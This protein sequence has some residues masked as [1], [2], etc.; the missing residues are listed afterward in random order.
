VTAIINKPQSG[1][2]SNVVFAGAD[3]QMLYVTDG[4]KV[5]RRHMRRKGTLAWTPLKPPV[6]QL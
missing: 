2:I 3:M 5:F 4:D 1:P 6:P